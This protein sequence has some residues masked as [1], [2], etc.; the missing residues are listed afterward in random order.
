MDPR[1]EK[2]EII[3]ISS[4]RNVLD[5]LPIDNDYDLCLKGYSPSQFHFA[6]NCKLLCVKPYPIVR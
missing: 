1:Q 3:F 4:L 5:M 2:S 6:N